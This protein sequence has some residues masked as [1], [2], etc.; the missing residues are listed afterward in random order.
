MLGVKALECDVLGG[1]HH[2]RDDVLLSHPI[3]YLEIV[4]LLHHHWA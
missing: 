1:I 3:V 4:A 2:D